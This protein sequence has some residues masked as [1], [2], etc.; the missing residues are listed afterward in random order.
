M[1]RHVEQAV[2]RVEAVGVEREP[3][4]LRQADAREGHVETW[5]QVVVE[6]LP[7]GPIH[8]DG[9]RDVGLQARVEADVPSE[10]AC[11]GLAASDDDE[12]GRELSIDGEQVGPGMT[13]MI[14]EQ[15]KKPRPLRRNNLYDLVEDMRRELP[16]DL[17]QTMERIKPQS[18]W[19]AELCLLVGKSPMTIIALGG[20]SPSL[21]ESS[22]L[23]PRLLAVRAIDDR[24]EIIRDQPEVTRLLRDAYGET[25]KA[26]P[27]IPIGLMTVPVWPGS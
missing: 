2:Q 16:S 6:R 10:R 9:N 8:A 12:R 22:Y 20:R 15:H 11:T 26:G 1:D 3:V 14:L 4:A 23:P 5:E 13:D 19:G 17:L 21:V 27:S 7:V 18:L 24:Q 25:V